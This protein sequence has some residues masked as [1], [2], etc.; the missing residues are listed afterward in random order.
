MVVE[1]FSQ[2]IIATVFSRTAVAKYKRSQESPVYGQYCHIERVL[3]KT[4]CLMGD[5]SHALL[6]FSVCDCAL[7]PWL[8]EVLE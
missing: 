8:Q 1:C 5:H 3:G 6:H 7:T 4:V 2:S